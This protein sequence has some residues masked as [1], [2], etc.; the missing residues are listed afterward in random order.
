MTETCDY[1]KQCCFTMIQIIVY[2]DPT[3]CIVIP[4][5]RYDSVYLY[6]ST[7]SNKTQVEP[8][9]NN[10]YLCSHILS[11]N[12]LSNIVELSIIDIPLTNFCF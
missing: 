7:R 4:M 12:V 2:D 11:N 3:F 9:L 5:V 1:Y 8:Y 10:D 6:Y